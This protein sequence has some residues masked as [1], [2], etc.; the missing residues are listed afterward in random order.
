[1]NA[2]APLALL[3]AGVAGCAA[4]PSS[5][6]A[7][8]DALTVGV[9][10]SDVAHP[11]IVGA[12][13]D[14]RRVAYAWP[15]GPDGNDTPSLAVLDTWTGA[16]AQLGPIARCQPKLVSFSADGALA[17]YPSSDGVASVWSAR[18]G[19]VVTVSRPGASAIALGFAPDSRWLVVASTPQPPTSFVDAW[20]ADL[21]HHVELGA[22]I[23][24]N[25][26]GA[27]DDAVKFSP[28]ARRV[29][30]LG[31]ASAPYP[32]GTLTE[33]DHASGRAR[34]LARGVA[35]YAVDDTFARVAFLDGV[36]VGSGPPSDWLHG[37][38]AVE[39]L[40]DGHLDV[41]ERD[42]PATPQYFAPDGTLVYFVGA[43]GCIRTG[44]D[45]KVAPPG[46]APRTVESNVFQTFGPA[47]SAA[48][49]PAGD[50]LAYVTAFDP[51]RFAGELHVAGLAGRAAPT[52][53]VP[54]VVPLAAF[55]WLDDT[56][57]Y[58][59][60]ST[61]SFPGGGLGTLGVWTAAGGARDLAT[62]TTQVGLRFDAA[63][64]R[65]VYFDHWDGGRAAGDLR[66]FSTATAKS[67]LLAHDAFAMSLS[68]SPADDAAGVITLGP[69]PD[70]ATAPRTTLVV[71]GADGPG[72]A[73]TI[74]R[75]VTSFA[76]ADGGRVFYTTDGGLWAAV[77]F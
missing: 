18:T 48:L 9:R 44:R 22:D 28:D 16:T 54:D 53:V 19:A 32:V 24:V 36:T 41:V 31:E 27:G 74:A 66:R 43:I 65:I 51:M 6:A 56:L 49:S 21:V 17:A 4:A 12:S 8:T 77:T 10:V 37:R 25:P 33:W 42:A 69:S 60:A 55:G 3:M 45:L 64:G 73:R 62:G 39:R 11:Q 63:A 30:Y 75:D 59:H 57:G 47:S 46:G 52:V 13:A 7:S 72:G 26:F 38:L 2:T 76:V 67:R 35:A 68:W 20:D 5:T 61:S 1:M 23:F 40:A 29:L 71:T 58:L 15:C 14:R 50:A 34:V 70:P